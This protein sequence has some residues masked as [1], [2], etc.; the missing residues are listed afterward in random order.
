[1]YGHF[2]NNFQPGFPS[3]KQGAGDCNDG[4]LKK[5]VKTGRACSKSN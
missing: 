5:A 1:M 2:L 3:K 4:S